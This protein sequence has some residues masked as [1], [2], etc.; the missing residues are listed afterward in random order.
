MVSCSH[1]L[2]NSD[3]WPKKFFCSINIP[4]VK[5]GHKSLEGKFSITR[6]FTGFENLGLFSCY[7]AA[8]K[9]AGISNPVKNL[10]SCSYIVFTLIILNSAHLFS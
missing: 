8:E 10:K 4:I 2:A 1:I 7:E 6:F 3:K 9:R 5:I